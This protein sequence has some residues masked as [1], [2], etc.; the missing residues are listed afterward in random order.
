MSELFTQQEDVVSLQPTGDCLGERI[1]LGAHPPP[2]QLS[3]RPCVC[4]TVEQPLQDLARR[5]PAHIA[6]DRGQ[7]D[8]GLMLASASTVCNRLVSRARASTR[9]IR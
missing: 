1:S 2:R 7:L 4:L 8:V 3:Q 6:H 9:W 5:Q